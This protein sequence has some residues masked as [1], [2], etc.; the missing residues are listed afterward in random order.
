MAEFEIGV[1][2]LP[3]L[4]R[5]AVL[6]YIESG[7]EPAS[8]LRAIFENDFV[9]AACNADLEDQHALLAYATFLFCD[10]PIECWGSAGKVDSWI[11]MGGLTSR[12]LNTSASWPIFFP[13]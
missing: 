13:N 7:I 6:R 12:H 2:R 4:K 8:F 1:R 5:P 11:A 10:A 3:R 9:H